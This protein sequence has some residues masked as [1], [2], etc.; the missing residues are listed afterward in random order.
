VDAFR[1]FGTIRG[2]LNGLG[3]GPDRR[4]GEGIGPEGVESLDARESVGAGVEGAWMESDCSTVRDGEAGGNGVETGLGGDIESSVSPAFSCPSSFSQLSIFFR[5]FASASADGASIR[6][7]ALLNPR[8]ISGG[9]RD[10][11]VWKPNDTSG[12]GAS[13]EALGATNALAVVKLAD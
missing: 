6:A 13:C 9:I 4:D 2:D 12:F 10:D 11:A 5:A 1:V 3:R 8:P 7:L